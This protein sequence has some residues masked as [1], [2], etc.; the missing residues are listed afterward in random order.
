MS[1]VLFSPLFGEMI[2]FDITVAVTIER[3]RSELQSW[4]PWAKW[5]DQ[6]FHDRPVWSFG[7]ESAWRGAVS[8]G[9]I[10]THSG[11]SHWIASIARAA[12]ATAY[13]P[14]ANVSLCPLSRKV[15]LVGNLMLTT[16]TSSSQLLQLVVDTQDAL[17][18]EILPHQ[19]RAAEMFNQVDM[20][21]SP[22]EATEKNDFRKLQLFVFQKGTNKKPSRQ[23][24]HKKWD[25]FVTQ[26]GFTMQ[27]VC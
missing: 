20:E 22:P 10:V 27:I 26:N 2:Q 14:K 25:R 18:S 24:K 11:E 13:C 6:G 15:R 16:S 12:P 5:Y 1:Y 8:A 23:N 21:T 7:K 3:D 4:K 17:T 19:W 9:A